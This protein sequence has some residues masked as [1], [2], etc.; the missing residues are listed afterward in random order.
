MRLTHILLLFVA[1]LITIQIHAQTFKVSG[2]VKREDNAP[3]EFANAVLKNGNPDNLADAMTDENGKF[4]IK[5]SPD[6]YVLSVSFVGYATDST[7]IMVDMYRIIQR[8]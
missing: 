8:N 1:I 6:K 4:E 7:E 3:I 2:I 5:V